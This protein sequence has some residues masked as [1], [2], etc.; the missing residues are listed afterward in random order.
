MQ[1]P[2]SLTLL[3]LESG[4]STWFLTTLS[5][6]ATAES[7]LR[8]KGPSGS[9]MGGTVLV[10]ALGMEQS[11]FSPQEDRQG[12]CSVTPITLTKI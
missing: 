6:T 5:K 4:Y 12:Q 11:F 2:N 3:K 8:E 9:S 7:G 10:L 1:T